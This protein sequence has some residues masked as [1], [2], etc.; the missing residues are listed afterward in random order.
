MSA[1]NEKCSNDVTS[2]S[3]LYMDNFF[4]LSRRLHSPAEIC[5]GAAVSNSNELYVSE[6]KPHFVAVT[7]WNNS[8]FQTVWYLFSSF[9]KTW[10]FTVV[11]FSNWLSGFLHCLIEVRSHDFISW[12]FREQSNTSNPLQLKFNRNGKINSRRMFT[13][14]QS[15]V[16]CWI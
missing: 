16:Y 13:A 8:H 12:G 11:S 14:C 10:T 1:S 4:E 9:L 7:V 2:H 15:L 5:T 6:L 3:F